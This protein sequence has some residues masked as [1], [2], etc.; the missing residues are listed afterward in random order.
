MGRYGRQKNDLLKMFPSQSLEP[1]I[2]LLP[3]RQKELCRSGHVRALQMRRF[4]GYLGECD[5][6]TGSFQETG[7]TGRD[8]KG[9]VTMAGQVRVRWGHQPREVGST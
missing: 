5:A 9:D 4:L 1:V 2:M 3:Y 6:A 7:S 8:S